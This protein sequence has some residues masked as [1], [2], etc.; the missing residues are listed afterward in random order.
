MKIVKLLSAALWTVLVAGV[1]LVVGV[2]LWLRHDHNAVCKRVE[3]ADHQAV[4]SACRQMMGERDEYRPAEEGRVKGMIDSVDSV[5]PRIP[6]AIRD[7]EP[8]HILVGTG[9]VEVVFQPGLSHVGFIAYPKGAKGKGQ[10]K[11]I[12]G[13]YMFYLSD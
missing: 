11:L 7:L 9:K 8:S 4:L 2:V 3:D 6:A 5:R 12:D 13:L 1:L 10:K